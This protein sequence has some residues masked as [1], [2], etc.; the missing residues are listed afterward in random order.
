MRKKL[1][2]GLSCL[3]LILFCFSG[4]E[5]LGSGG[6]QYTASGTYTYN[7]GTMVLTTITTNSTLPVDEGTTLG[8]PVSVKVGSLTATQ[9]TFLNNS[10]NVVDITFT[11]PSGTAGN[12]IGTWTSSA[13]GGDYVFKFNVDGTWSYFANIK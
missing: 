2:A 10:T 4:C 9:M 1:F 12:I 11:R 5:F 7:S 8:K 13:R 3:L 6:T